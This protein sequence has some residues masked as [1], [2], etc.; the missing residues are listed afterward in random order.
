MF[1]AMG[2]QRNIVRFTTS[3]SYWEK[4]ALGNGRI[5]FCHCYL[6]KDLSFIENAHRWK[7][8]ATVA[9]I[10]T[11]RYIKS[12]GKKERGRRFYFT[13]SNASAEVI[14]NPYAH[15]GDLKINCTGS[16]R[17]LFPKINL[18]NGRDMRRKIFRSSTVLL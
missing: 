7:S 14:V 8:L 12:S 9:K 15:T 18:V 3:T 4:E 6:Y 17:S 16:W 1:D 10:E 13:S 5:D 2:C 11:M